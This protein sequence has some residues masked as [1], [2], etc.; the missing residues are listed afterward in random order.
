MVKSREVETDPDIKLGAKLRRYL[1][2]PKFLHLLHSKS[3][4]L[5]RADGFADRFEG[6]LTPIFR[7]TLDDAHKNGELDHNADYFYRRAR[8]G[9]YVSCWTLGTTDNMALWQLYGG[10]KTSVAV[11]TTVERLVRV[12]LAWNEDV[13]IHRVQY[14]DHTKN[15]DMII[16]RYTDVLRYKNEAYQYENELR[17]LVPRQGDDWDENPMGIELSVGKLSDLIASVVIAPDADDWF[18]NVVKD[19]CKKYQ[20]SVPIRRSRLSYLPT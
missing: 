14:I 20:V 4:Y 7:R 2:L 8:V 19:L 3:L 1:D 13:R 10:T 9:N 16:G 5:R 12:S 6:A 11:N 17:L 18:V 15:P